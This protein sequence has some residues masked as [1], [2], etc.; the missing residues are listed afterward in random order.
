[1]AGLIITSNFLPSKTPVMTIPP[2]LKLSAIIVTIVGLLVALELASLTSKQFKAS[3]FLPSHNFSNM[4]GFFPATVHR[5]VPFLNLSLGQSIASQM[6]DQ[7]WFEKAGPKA[8]AS[9]QLPLVTSTTHV[10]QGMIKTYLAMFFL[11]LALAA[12]VALI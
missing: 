6:V 10:Q 9:A 3:P 11:A 2:L 12:S 5:I 8:V 4:L 1:M 7:T